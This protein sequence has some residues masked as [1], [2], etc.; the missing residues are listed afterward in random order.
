MLPGLEK[1]NLANV[2]NVFNGSSIASTEVNTNIISKIKLLS[3][4][5]KEIV[6]V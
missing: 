1:L 5:D 2:L 6:I 4:L 3:Y